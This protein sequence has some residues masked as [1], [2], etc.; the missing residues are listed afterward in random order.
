MNNVTWLASYPKSGNTW[1]RAFLSA[2]TGK[3]C[4]VNINGLGS[5]SIASAMLPFEFATGLRVSDL[6]E[7]EAEELRPLAH[8]FLADKAEGHYFLKVHDAYIHTKRNGPMFPTG[9]THSAVYLMRNPLDVTVSWANHSGISIQTAVDQLNDAE[10]CL[11]R[12]A[13]GGTLGIQLRQRMFTW[14]RHVESWVDAKE[15]KVLPIRY[16]DLKADAVSQFSRLVEFTGLDKTRE[17]V[18]RAEEQ[19]RFDKLKQQEEEK[20]FREK[21]AGCESFFHRG[22][23]GY[24]KDELNDEQV[25]AIIETNFDVMQRFGYLDESGNPV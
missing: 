16:E 13:P 17:E 25:A 3:E 21:R 19:C 8:Q 2:L 4:E 5:I 10:H 24:W 18:V 12:R 6:T 23:T 7:D 22:Q 9:A 20:G 1:T 14:A 15:I 11:S